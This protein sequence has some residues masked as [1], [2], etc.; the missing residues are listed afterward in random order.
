MERFKVKH[1]HSELYGIEGFKRDFIPITVLMAVM[2]L[3]IEI[4][5]WKPDVNLGGDV[6]YKQMETNYHDMTSTYNR[7]ND[8]EGN[9]YEYWS[10][11]DFVKTTIRMENNNTNTKA[12]KSENN[13]T[14]QS[15]SVE[16]TILKTPE[17]VKKVEVTVSQSKPIKNA[18]KEK[19]SKEKIVVKLGKPMDV[20]RKRPE[21]I[22][23]GNEKETV[24][25]TVET[26]T[27]LSSSTTKKSEEEPSPVGDYTIEH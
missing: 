23:K 9:G 1:R 18:K 25:T 26:T 3:G 13:V 24:E 7:E 5:G 17:M 11:G 16:N 4:T 6:S 15:E 19:K 20:T 8:N 14:T 2:V 21:I 22:S 27:M 12:I 10:H